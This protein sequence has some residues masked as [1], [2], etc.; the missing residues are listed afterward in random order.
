M[1]E[2]ITNKIKDL[3]NQIYKMNLMI[4]NQGLII[5]ELQSQLVIA[6]NNIVSYPPDIQNILLKSRS[7]LEKIV[8]EIY[9]KHYSDFSSESN[10]YNCIKKLADNKIINYN[11][12]I[13]FNAI[14]A[15]CNFGIHGG[16]VDLA[17]TILVFEL[18]LQ[19]IEWFISYQSVNNPKKIKEEIRCSEQKIE[20]KTLNDYINEE[21]SYL[22]DSFQMEMNLLNQKYDMDKISK[23]L[24]IGDSK[25]QDML[26]DLSNEI[27]LLVG[28]K[29][30]E[31]NSVLDN[32]VSKVKSELD[33]D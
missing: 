5:K 32:V 25:G 29:S 8:S 21:I 18:S 4:E 2:D 19:L 24:L 9:S 11:M 22:N 26:N 1:S 15:M 3:E 12:I 23:Y 13:R 33:N 6:F 17:D 16:K 14:R 30:Q 27:T 28:K 10:L 31:V 20:K 7:V